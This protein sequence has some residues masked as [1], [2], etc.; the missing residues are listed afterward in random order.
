M[1]NHFA[2]ACLIVFL[3]V[4]TAV[5]SGGAPTILV[6]HG[7]DWLY[8]KGTNAPPADWKMVADGALVSQG[9]LT[10][11]GGL[12]Y[13]GG[14]EDD[15]CLTLLPDM[16]NR[17]STLYY[18]KSFT[19]V[20]AASPDLHLLLRMDWDDGFIAWLDGEYLTSRQ[21]TGAPAE[22]E[23]TATAS[24]NHESS[25]GNSSAQSAETFDLGLIGT[26][27]DAGDHVLAIMGLNVVLD[28]SDFIQVAD[29][30][31]DTVVEPPPGLELGGTLSADTT[32]YA[33]NMI[34]TVTSDLTVA[35]G[36]TLRIEPGVTVEFKGG[37]DLTVAAGGRLLAEGTEGERITF[38]RASGASTWGG[39][40]LR[41]N[42][43]SPESRLVYVHIAYNG[44]T[45]VHGT[46][47]TALFDHLTFGTAARQFLSLD[48]SSFIVSYCHFPEPTASFE[49]VHGTGGVKSGGYGIFYRNY[50]GPITGY[51]DVIDFAGG[52]RS[53]PIP[54][55]IGNVFAGSGDDQVDLDNA[56]AWV[57]GNIFLHAHKNGPP[58]TSSAISGGNDTGHP[59]E[60]TIVG[61][62]FFDC[63]QVVLVKQDN[64]FVLLNNTIVH[65]TH[66]GGLDTEGAVLCTQDNNMRE[67]AAVY[68]EANIIHDAEALTRDVELALIT[69]S[70]NVMQLPWTGP[71]SGNL[72]DD[73]LFVYV[74]QVAETAFTNWADAQVMW[75]WFAL[76]PGSPALGTGPE[77][78]DIG[79]TTPGVHLTG[80][81]TGETS[82]TNA[83]LHVSILRAGSGIHTDG[84]PD[85]AGYTHYKWRL[86]EGP[87]S[88]ETPV[89]D[90]ITLVDLPDG[91]HFV[92]VVG[93]N[94]AGWYRDDPLFGD[95]ARTLRSGIWTVLA[96]AD[97]DGLPDGWEDA[98]GLDS[99]RDD[100]GEDPDG[101]RMPNDAEWTAGTDP[102]NPASWL[103]TQLAYL[104][105]GGF[106]VSFAAVSNRVYDLEY[107]PSLEQG[108]WTFLSTFPA[109][110]TN[111]WI[112][113]PLQNGVNPDQGYLRLRVV[114]E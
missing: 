5:C 71:G 99:T 31:M 93:K 59:S 64:T 90:P 82:E 67:G 13:A 6:E 88:A 95:E 50:F 66:I 69:F 92:E 109:A 65:Q 91:D 72:A 42:A 7:A 87:W 15:Q 28:S 106:T 23:H 85:G 22:P 2:S 45:A 17:Y 44:S 25:L 48:R 97:E 4:L 107:R 19:L 74:P 35:D 8:H 33:S 38:T 78:R 105:P 101:D 36:V 94:D 27:L 10:G 83:L 3:L 40:T 81:P 112:Q 41:G 52:D 58:D 14:T 11:P 68:L 51:N 34:Y 102:A 9:W 89:Q 60:L 114:R 75:D 103:G 86:D 46:D 32:L 21:V 57:E 73:P 20:E 108:T 29:L 77:G 56:D 96:D 1:K 111:R 26:R 62:L 53:G 18:R 104:P 113:W 39:I 76:Q 12:G 63:D 61:N 80:L 30:S 110:G 43:G 70:N 16:Q 49:P 98:H 100:A 84:W 37:T 47:A 79:A 54:Q 55:F 24:G